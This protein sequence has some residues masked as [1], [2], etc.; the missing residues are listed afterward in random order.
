M[1]EDR[2]AQEDELLALTSIYDDE[3]FHRAE[4]AQ[5]GE[6]QL[7]LELPP[8]FKIVVKGTA[9]SGEVLCNKSKVC[10]SCRVGL[11]SCN[12]Q[13]HTVCN[14]QCCAKVK[15]LDLLFCA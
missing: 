13:F 15:T 6:I 10:N 3:E 4:S 7:C 9:V 14:V 11:Q 2:E 12:R 5:G 1:S 8:D